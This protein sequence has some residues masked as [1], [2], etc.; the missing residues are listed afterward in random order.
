MEGFSL[1]TCKGKE[2][3]N[4]RRGGSFFGLMCFLG[5]EYNN[6]LNHNKKAP[7]QDKKMISRREACS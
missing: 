3:K 2:R 1:H 6:N 7:F 5:G 4:I